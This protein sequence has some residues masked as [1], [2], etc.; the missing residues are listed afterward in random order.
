MAAKK[1][2]RS[3]GRSDKRATARIMDNQDTANK[4]DSRAERTA[5][6]TFSTRPDLTARI[7]DEAHERRMSRSQLI[8]AALVAYL[9]I[10]E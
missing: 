3:L 10:D 4:G 2:Q 8:E 1:P 9:D 5:R 6:V 7:T